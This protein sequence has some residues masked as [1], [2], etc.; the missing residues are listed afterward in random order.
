MS[1]NRSIYDKEAYDLQLNR[2]TQPGD[3]RLFASFAERLDSCFSYNGPVNAKSDVSL[4]REQTNLNN[5]KMAQ[6][7][8]DL[9]WRNQRLSKSNKNYNP[10]NDKKLIN[11]TNCNN[12]LVSEDTRFTHPIDNYRAMSLTEYFYEP[13]V[14]VNPQCHIHDPRLGLDSRLSAKD[15]YVLP[16]QHFWDN[17]SALPKEKPCK[18]PECETIKWKPCAYLTKI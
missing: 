17:G 9:S 10:L 5:E 16:K 8:S 13:Y 14:H 7:E 1:F 12:K 3:Y 2:S 4:V 18:V 6:T 11:K 15:A